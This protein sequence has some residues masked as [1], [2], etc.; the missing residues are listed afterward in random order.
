MLVSY[1]FF[2]RDDLGALRANMPCGRLLIDSGAF[3]AASVGKRIELSAY[4]EFLT[5]WAHVYDH[6]VTLDV[7]GDPVATRR[8]THALHRKGINVLPVFTRGGTVADFDAMVRDSGYVCV[9][10]GV[11]MPPTVVVK[12]LRAL[13]VRAEEL[14]G[15]IHALGVGNMTGLRSI[16]PYS[17]DA[18][19]ISGAFRFGTVVAYDGRRMF[20]VPVSD[21]ARLRKH[22]ALLKDQGL[23]PEVTDLVRTGRQPVKLGRAALM[24]GMSVAYAAADED[25]VRF[26]V[27]VPKG[28]HDTSGTHLYSAVTGSHLA[29]A[30]AR[31]DGALH[32]GT[33]APPMWQRRA[34]RHRAQCRAPLAQEAQ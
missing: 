9:G 19:N 10:G 18:S 6:A 5:T 24:R 21:R 32:S 2:A 27:P 13:Q 34:A 17:A 28:V 7:I 30:V 14:G 29:P 26:G 20:N 16:R 15:G 11:G 23:G 1:A 3:T 8:N 25:T 33:F 4:A 12:R 22:L 31:L